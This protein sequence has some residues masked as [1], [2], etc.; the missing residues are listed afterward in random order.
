MPSEIFHRKGEVTYRAPYFDE[1]VEGKLNPQGRLPKNHV[2][3]ALFY[4]N[5]IAA[6][7]LDEAKKNLVYEHELSK[8]FE[9]ADARRLIESVAFMYNT[10][11]GEMVRFWDV[12]DAQR[13]ALGS[14]QNADLPHAMRFRFN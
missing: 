9:V 11:P 6:K 14:N 7:N 8:K 2:A 1:L 12:V 10:T 3:H 5:L 13:R 4:Y